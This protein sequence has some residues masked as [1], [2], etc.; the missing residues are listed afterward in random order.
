M[1]EMLWFDLRIPMQNTATP[2]NRIPQRSMQL[3]SIVGALSMHHVP[4]MHI[5]LTDIIHWACYNIQFLSLQFS[6]FKGEV[7]QLLESWTL[8]LESYC[9]GKK[10]CSIF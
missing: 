6:T 2:N 4:F 9:D 8:S 1:C 3:R 10:T 7:H 5:Y